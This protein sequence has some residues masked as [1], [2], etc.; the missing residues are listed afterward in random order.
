MKNKMYLRL[1]IEKFKGDPDEVAKTIGVKPSS[2]FRKGDQ[3]GTSKLKCKW[4]A[5]EYRVDANRSYDLE[6]LVSSLMGKF[7]DKRKLKKAISLGKAELVC[8]LY[9]SDRSPVLTLSPAQ[10][11]MLAD[12]KCSFSVDY[13]L[14]P[15]N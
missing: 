5:L 9:T 6:K 14:V 11:K 3:I 8:V 13:Y 10:I 2:V 7:K 4:N 12:L 15:I 1:D